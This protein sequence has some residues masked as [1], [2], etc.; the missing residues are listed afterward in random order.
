MGRN[1]VGGREERGHERGDPE[2]IRGEGQESD[3]P[4][5]GEIRVLARNG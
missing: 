1:W 3:L 5:A 4:E 2:E